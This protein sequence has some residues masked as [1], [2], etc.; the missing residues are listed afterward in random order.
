MHN[1]W[2]RYE[3]MMEILALKWSRGNVNGS[4]MVES[5]D[6]GGAENVLTL[7]LLLVLVKSSFEGMVVT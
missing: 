4:M 7:L 1:K 2:H 6:D 3:T 5:K